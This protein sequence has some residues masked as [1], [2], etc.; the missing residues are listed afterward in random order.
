[1]NIW[2]DGDSIPRDIRQ[3][4][5]RRGSSNAPKTSPRTNPISV[6]FVSA[7]RLP[8]VPAEMAWL[9]AAGQDATDS[10][11]ESLVATGDLVVTRDIPLAERIASKN[12]AVI[13][14]RGEFFT[15]EKA[16][17]RRSLRD[18][19]AELRFLG[20]APASPRGSKR[21]AKDTKLFA[22][23]LDRTLA[24]MKSTTTT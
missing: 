20:I 19:A 13:N 16:A 1:V 3:I 17:E 4:L 21:T 10:Y 6:L 23:S 18:A 11:I 15:K 8:D 24:G 14:D 22:D 12:I 2:V 5:I 7:R 9:V